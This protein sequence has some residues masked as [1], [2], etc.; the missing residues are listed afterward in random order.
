[1]KVFMKNT[2]LSFVVILLNSVIYFTGCS[3]SAVSKQES[4]N[5]QVNETT[6]QLQRVIPFC[7]LIEK[8]NEYDAQT[9]Q[10]SAILIAGWESS[11]LYSPGCSDFQQTAWYKSEN[12]SVENK[13]APYFE[14]QR[15]DKN[16]T[17]RVKITVVGKFERK[18]DKG[19][20]HL[21]AFN[22]AFTAFDIK[23]VTPV[24]NDAPTT[25]FWLVQ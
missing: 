3:S 10:T 14:P 19:F 25:R 21:N 22:F 20:G 15:R 6:H 4:G 9:I 12:W 1:M 7:E 17:A 13:I 16:G 24:S 23:E 18:K 11:Y 2:Q 8:S 5:F